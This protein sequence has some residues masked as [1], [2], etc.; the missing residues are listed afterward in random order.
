MKLGGFPER[1]WLGRWSRPLLPV[2]IFVLLATI[3][4]P[5]PEPLP[6]E[7]GEARLVATPIPLDPGDPGHRDVGRLHFLAGWNLDSDDERFGG[8]SGMHVEAGQ[9]TA[10]S[11]VGIVT[12]FPVPGPAL[13]LPVRFDPLIEGPGPRSRRSSRD[14]EGLLADRD[15]LWVSFERRHM[16]W[17]YDRSTLRAEA[18][19]R[20]EPMQSW[21]GNSGAEALLRLADGRFLVFAEGRDDGAPYSDVM[22]FAGDP[23][24][25]ETPAVRLR[26]RRP[27]GFRPTDA[28]LLPDGRILILNR[29]FAWLRLSA[30]L[31]I[32]DAT[33]LAAGGTIEG[34]E[35]A[36]LESPLNL[37]NMEALAI[38]VENGRTIVWIA[39][40]DDFMSIVRRTLLLK[41]ELR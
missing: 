9:V 16:V 6:W 29:R 11:D 28:A 36:T 39:S 41:F 1:I 34:Q 18:A 32:A 38:T 2:A 15:H 24:L 37:D 17:R 20:P 26:Y 31:M 30:R 12:R 19:A 22:L 25:P 8:L 3:V 27:D 13:D 5:G 10:I 21:R 4:S 14:S 35:V 40:D 33:G 23:A 7:A